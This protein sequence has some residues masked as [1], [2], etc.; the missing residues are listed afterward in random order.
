MGADIY[1]TDDRHISSLHKR[2]L[3]DPKPTDVMTF[4][5]GQRGDVIISLDTA[6]RQAAGRKIP[7]RWELTLLA[8]HG[9]LHLRGFKDRKYRDWQRMRV[10]EFETVVKI[11]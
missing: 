11:I 1:L 9:I 6:M 5:M 3:D 4:P 8:V 2:F 10:A 7:L